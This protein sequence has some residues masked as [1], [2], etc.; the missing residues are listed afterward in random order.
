MLTLAA[1]D[2]GELVDRACAALSAGGDGFEVQ[3]SAGIVLI[4]AE[5]DRIAT[6]LAL[7]DDRMY[8]S[9]ACRRETIERPAREEPAGSPGEHALSAASRA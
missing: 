8:R 7:A 4:P 1:D 2:A 9:K 5:A 6:A 3:A